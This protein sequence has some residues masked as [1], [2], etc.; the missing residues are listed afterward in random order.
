MSKC[1]RMRA[2]T[3]HCRF[4]HRCDRRFGRPSFGFWFAFWVR[5][6]VATT[7][8]CTRYRMCAERSS[9]GRRPLTY[10]GA[11]SEPSA[12]SAVRGHYLFWPWSPSGLQDSVLFLRIYRFSHA[13]ATQAARQRWP[14][15]PSPAGPTRSTGPG[16]S[17]SALPATT[18]A[19]YLTH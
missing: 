2:S 10:A 19:G 16:S 6:S 4:W 15:R 7:G 11:G 17:R 1:E 9:R 3:V 12:S 18:S 13:G 8:N 14:P 5:Y